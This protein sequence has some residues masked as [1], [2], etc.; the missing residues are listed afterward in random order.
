MTPELLRQYLDVARKGGAQVVQLKTAAGDEL[1][2]QLA[3][4]LTALTP[5]TPE[6]IEKSLKEVK[7]ETLYGSAGG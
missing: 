3:P 5:R 7:D 4:D 6:E 2:L 1:V